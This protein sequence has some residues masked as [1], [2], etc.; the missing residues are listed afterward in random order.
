MAERPTPAVGRFGVAVRRDRCRHPS[1]RPHGHPGG[2]RHGL[3]L[4][5]V[6]GAAARRL[7]RAGCERRQSPPPS[8]GQIVL[9]QGATIR[10]ASRGPW[11]PRAPTWRARRRRVARGDDDLQIGSDTHAGAW[12]GP[13]RE[14]RLRLATG[15]RG[16][17]LF[18]TALEAANAETDQQRALVDQQR[19]GRPGD[20]TRRGRG[21]GARQARGREPAQ[22]DD[23]EE[24]T[25][26]RQP[27][28]SSTA[29]SPAFPYR[30]SGFREHGG[31]RIYLRARGTGLPAGR[32]G[33]NRSF[34]PSWLAT[35][36][37]RS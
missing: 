28:Y 1:D 7:A 29:S 2:R 26:C 21:G 31:G 5:D 10:P 30:R 6:Q 12:A 22:E 8:A 17:A 14:V 20:R 23:E 18:P 13:E 25:A 16:D 37:S 15:E 36:P 35:N 24:V 4:G 3:G 19:A 11:L 32:Q 33:S 27:R 9:P 34:M